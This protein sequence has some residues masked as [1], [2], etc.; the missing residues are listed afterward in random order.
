MTSAI[1]TDSLTKY[2]GEHLGI[3]N[4][5]LD[6]NEGEVFSLLGPNGAGKT[7]TIRV[8]LDFIRPT[9][10]TATV[11]GLDTVNDSVAIRDKVGYLPGDF[12]HV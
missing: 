12:I 4:L 11:L 3:R 7:T 8:F 10:G 9:S 6:I 1:K 2:Y 5:S